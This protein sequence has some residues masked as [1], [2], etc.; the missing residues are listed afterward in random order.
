MDRFCVLI[1]KFPSMRQYW[2]NDKHIFELE[3][4]KKALKQGAMS[5]GEK[6]ILS[7]LITIYNPS[8]S[9]CEVNFS[10]LAALSFQDRIPLVTFLIDPFWP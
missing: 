10:D 9:G 6:V 5:R 2:N 8:N 3:K 4:A 7:C 1:Q